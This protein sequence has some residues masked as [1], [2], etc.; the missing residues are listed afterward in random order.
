MGL[1]EGSLR[2]DSKEQI[3]LT[4]LSVMV[5]RRSTIILRTTVQL[6]PTSVVYDIGSDDQPLST[7][8]RGADV[9]VV[10]CAISGRFD[11]GREALRGLEVRRAL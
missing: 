8:L 3:R 11:S 2:K 6:S 1:P 4:V 5:S 7:G 9:D 10:I